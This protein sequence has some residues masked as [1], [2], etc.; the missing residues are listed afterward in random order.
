[1]IINNFDLF[2]EFYNCVKE[3]ESMADVLKEY[4][5]ANIYVPSYK[6]TF[7]NRDIIKDYEE[8]VAAGKQSTVIIRE[9]ATK[10]GLSYNSIS[11]IVKENRQPGLFDDEDLI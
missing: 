4:G 11:S 2:V 9:I 6:S 8:G 7:R 5:G 1:M 3:S 10:H